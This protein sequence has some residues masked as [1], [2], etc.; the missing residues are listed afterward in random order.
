[1]KRYPVLGSFKFY[2]D[3]LHA[4]PAVLRKDLAQLQSVKVWAF[5]DQTGSNSDL[6]KVI[7]SELPAWQVSKIEDSVIVVGEKKLAAFRLE[8][9]LDTS[10]K[11]AE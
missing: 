1:M 4:A 6:E 2:I 7:S 8:K 11:S 5:V 9:A 3:R 10:S